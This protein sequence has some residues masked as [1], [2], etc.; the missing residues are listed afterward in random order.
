MGREPISHATAVRGQVAGVGSRPHCRRRRCRPGYRLGA[1]HHDHRPDG[2]PAACSSTVRVCSAPL[3]PSR[4]RV[5]NRQRFGMPSGIW[6]VAP[7]VC[8]RTARRQLAPDRRPDLGSRG[9][10]PAARSPECQSSAG[11]VHRAAHRIRASS[12]WAAFVRHVDWARAPLCRGR[13]RVP[14][15]SPSSFRRRRLKSGSVAMLAELAPSGGGL[16]RSSQRC[17]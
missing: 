1:A 17:V 11:R 2:I 3:L 9:D 8:Y 15:L 10:N 12:P 16:S 7:S 5:R 13:S 14:L 4:P 6:V